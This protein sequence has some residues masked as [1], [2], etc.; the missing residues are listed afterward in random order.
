[1]HFLGNRIS[2]YFLKNM[3]ESEIGDYV[4]HLDLIGSV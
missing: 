2:Y 1:M 3:N 4:V